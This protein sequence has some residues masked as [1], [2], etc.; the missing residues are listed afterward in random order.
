VHRLARPIL[1][2]F[3]LISVGSAPLAAQRRVQLTVTVPTSATPVL[4]S[5]T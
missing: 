4:V 3:A 5:A 1:L 2:T